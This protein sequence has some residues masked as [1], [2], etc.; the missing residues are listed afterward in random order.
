MTTIYQYI[1]LQR[2]LAFLGLGATLGIAG[3]VFGMNW[4][5]D[6]KAVLKSTNDNALAGKQNKEQAIKKLNEFIEMHAVAKELS[7][8]AILKN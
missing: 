4:V 5:S 3:L 6:M 8:L 1:S 7:V 2:F